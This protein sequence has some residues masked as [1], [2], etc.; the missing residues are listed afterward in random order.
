MNR[1]PTED[2]LV[3]AIADAARAAI[4]DLFQA[5]SG[6]TFYYCSLI[7]TGEG[8]P[9]ELSAWSREALAQAA[10]NEPDAEAELKWS[11]ADS[12][13]CGHGQP[14]LDRLNEVFDARPAPDPAEV[15]VRLGAMERAMSRLDTE[16]LFG[17]GPARDQLVINVEV[18]PPDYTNVRR[19][20]RL[21]PAAALLEWLDEAAEPEEQD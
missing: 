15:D 8:H 9:P 14:H 1:I 5:H 2:E 3:D 7:T 13:Y 17:T 6:E 21:N 11:Y 19:A 18:M 20:K 4:S 12:P 16:G 10:L